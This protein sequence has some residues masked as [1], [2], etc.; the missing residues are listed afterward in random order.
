M[1]GAHG[2]RSSINWS[3]RM[4]SALQLGLLAT[5]LFGVYPAC[6]SEPAITPRPRVLIER[7]GPA[8]R[9]GDRM[10]V[11]DAPGDPEA[12]GVVRYFAGLMR[13]SGRVRRAPRGHVGRAPVV[14]FI[15]R[16]G[17]GPEGYSLD[18]ARAGATVTASSRA[19]L[20]YGAI[21]LWQLLT[22]ADR[23][24]VARLHI[25]DG[26]RFAWRGLM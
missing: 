20:L 25:E 2:L 19:G 7:P 4:R 23:G 6:A 16:A 12:R 10:P 1:I 13:R 3:A 15:R 9:F 11:I 5:A 8:V 14:R 26:P 21:T 22:A 24:R 18:I 17:S